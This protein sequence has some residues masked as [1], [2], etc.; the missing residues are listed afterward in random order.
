MSLGR[1]RNGSAVFFKRKWASTKIY[2]SFFPQKMFFL[3]IPETEESAIATN[4][5][6]KNDIVERP[7]RT[8]WR[9]KKKPLLVQEKWSETY[10]GN[11]VRTRGWRQKKRRKTGLRPALLFSNNNRRKCIEGP[12]N[13]KEIIVSLSVSFYSGRKRRRKLMGWLEKVHFK[14]GSAQSPV[15]KS[16]H[17]ARKSA[18]SNQCSFRLTK[19]YKHFRRLQFRLTQFWAKK[20]SKKFKR[21]SWFVGSHRCSIPWAHQRAQVLKIW[22]RRRSFR[23]W[24]FQAFSGVCSSLAR[25]TL[26]PKTGTSHPAPPCPPKKNQGT[27]VFCSRVGCVNCFYLSKTTAVWTAR[28]QLKGSRNG[29]MCFPFLEEFVIL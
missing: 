4:T 7:R 12:P 25:V 28:P 1:N 3:K 2:R 23:W 18:K 9:R 26:S 16:N 19:N 5:K 29:K 11:T 22:G 8:P 14:K 21:K 10:E 13:L 6:R 17:S 20:S 15:E 27:I 24:F